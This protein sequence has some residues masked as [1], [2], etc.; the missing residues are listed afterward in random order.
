MITTEEEEEALRKDV[1]GDVERRENF[2][3]LEIANPTVRV[4]TTSEEAK[5]Y[6]F[7]AKPFSFLSSHSFIHIHAHSMT[8]YLRT[9]SAWK[10]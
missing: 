3:H 7:M 8:A 6:V 10:Y 5:L 4:M 9:H 2:C 1:V